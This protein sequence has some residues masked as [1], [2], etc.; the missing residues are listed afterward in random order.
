MGPEADALVSRLVQIYRGEVAGIEAHTLCP[1]DMLSR[2]YCLEVV[3]SWLLDTAV[4]GQRLLAGVG[5]A[6]V[7]DDVCVLDRSDMARE[8]IEAD[9]A[10][11]GA[12]G[13]DLLQGDCDDDMAG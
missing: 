8:A 7:I 10:A 2:V 11:D 9:A 1:P 5:L 4:D 3:R 13:G 12:C 6:I